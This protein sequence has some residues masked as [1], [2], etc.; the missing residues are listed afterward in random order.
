M[1]VEPIAGNMGCI[2]PNLNWLIGLRRQTQN[3]GALLIYDEVMTGFRVAYGG[4]QERYGVMPDLTCLGKIV[5]GGLPL[6][7]YGGKAEIMEQVAPTGPVYQAGTLSGNPIA[8]AA[9]LQTLQ[10]LRQSGVYEELEE[11][12]AQLQGIIEG[13]IQKHNIACTVHR[14]GS[15]L[16]VFFRDKSVSNWNDVLDTDRERFARWHRALLEHG[17]YWPCSQ[18]EAAFVSFKHDADALETT[19]R[20]MDGSLW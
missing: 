6:G 15:M 8:V 18:F 10:L 5:G 3:Y 9:G 17:V 1:I 20:A 13:M 2:P 12:G 11:K 14:V 7:V 4:A 19:H 16:T